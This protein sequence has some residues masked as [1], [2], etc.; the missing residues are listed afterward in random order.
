MFN[1]RSFRYTGSPLSLASR[2]R[3]TVSPGLPIPAARSRRCVRDLIRCGAGP[4]QTPVVAAPCTT[5]PR[6]ISSSPTRTRAP[7]CAPP[8]SARVR[9]S[10]RSTAS[11]S[12]S[13]LPA[14]SPSP[15]HPPPPQLPAPV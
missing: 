15:V 1:P 3:P 4:R 5:V 6:L 11:R 10:T 12:S 14:T 13:H 9:C 8:E 7:R 2:S